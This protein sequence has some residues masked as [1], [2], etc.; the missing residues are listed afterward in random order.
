MHTLPKVTGDGTKKGLIAACLHEFENSGGGDAIAATLPLGWPVYA[1]DDQT[2]SLTNGGGLYPFLGV[3][4]GMSG[5]GKPMV[6]VGID[7]FGFMSRG[8]VIP[9][10]FGH[11]DLTAAATSESFDLITLPGPCR[12][13]GPPTFDSLTVFTGGSA[14]VV[15]L[16][17]GIDTGPDVDAI[18][19]EKSIFTGATAPAAMTAGVLGF[20]GAPIAAGVKITYTVASDVNVVALNAGACVASLRL[21]PGS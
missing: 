16:A 18:G 10:K 13:V 8:L 14:T 12:V 21:M 6:C 1:A 3:F 9:I 19:D 20:A 4:A 2:A 17:V 5:N 15:T 11:A 7:P